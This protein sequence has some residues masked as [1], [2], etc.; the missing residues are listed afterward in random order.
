VLAVITAACSTAVVIA[1]DHSSKSLSVEDARGNLHVPTD[2]RERYEFLGSWAAG[3]G[4]QIHNV[5]ASPG[6]RAAF[7]RTGKFPDGTVLV[8]EQFE[9]ESATMTSGVS[10]HATNLL[11]WFVLVKN[12]NNRHSDNPL[13]GDGWGW[14]HFDLAAPTKTTATNYKSDCMPCHIPAQKTDYIYLQGYPGLR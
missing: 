10:S 11:G 3:G 12:D 9:A 4:K 1:D 2:Y 14:S 5:Y 7:K 6:T 8:K 13:W